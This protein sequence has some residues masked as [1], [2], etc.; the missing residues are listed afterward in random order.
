[1]QPRLV[2]RAKYDSGSCSTPRVRRKRPCSQSPACRQQLAAAV[3]AK[4][5]GRH[6]NVLQRSEPF[7]A[8]SIAP[9][10]PPPPNVC[11]L[12]QVAGFR[13][14]LEGVLVQ[15]RIDLTDDDHVRVPV[16]QLSGDRG[17]VTQAHVCAISHAKKLS[18]STLICVTTKPITAA[19]SS[20]P[21]GSTSGTASIVETK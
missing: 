12:I 4:S 1:M 8:S 16:D 6:Q 13:Q 20:S 3:L 9:C 2:A 21:P 19:S 7:R 17:R 14:T 10:A 5:T 15:R 11:G 18:R